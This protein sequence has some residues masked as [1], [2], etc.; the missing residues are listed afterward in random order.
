MKKRIALIYGGEGCE[1]SISLMSARRTFSLLDNKKYD[2]LPIFIS[3]TGGWYI[4]AYDPM[5]KLPIEGGT[6]TFPVM[7]HGNSGFLS[8]E[9]IISVDVAIPILHGNHG[10]DGIIQGVLEAAH[11]PYVGCDVLSSAICADKSYTK[12]VASSLSIPTARWIVEYGTDSK[13]KLRARISA[14]EKFFYPMFI[15]PARLGSSIGARPVMC[16]RE[17]DA[18]FLDAAKYNAGVLIEEHIPVKYEVECAYL[19]KDGASL[20]SADGRVKTEGVAY[21]FKEKYV[22]GKTS[23][24]CDEKNPQKQKIEALAEKLVRALG[25]RDMARIDFF[26]TER[27]EV[28]FNEINTI[29]GMTERSLYPSLTEKMGLSC[30][31]FLDV[32]ID[33]ATRC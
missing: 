5:G 1:R 20:F 18:A 32:L 19:H 3:H 13:S 12:A 6:P 14:E 23:A 28:Y 2:V 10:E 25:I 21:S 30:G 22:G 33:N 9:K 4:G 31:E 29:P 8:S 11:I 24:G 27:G 26:V 7:L 15:K 17:F 16:E